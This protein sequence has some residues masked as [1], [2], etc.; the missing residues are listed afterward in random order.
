VNETTNGG[1][2]RRG[3]LTLA[4]TGLGL[5]FMGSPLQQLLFTREALGATPQDAS[6][7]AFLSIYFRGGPSQTDTW[8]PKPGSPSSYPGFQTVDLGVRDVYGAP[9]R[10]GGQFSASEPV[11]PELANLVMNDRD[12]K[13]GLVR[14]FWHG[15]NAHVMAQTYMNCWWRSQPLVAQYPSMASAMAYYL[16]GRGPGIPA[17]VIT[18][19]HGERVNDAGQS[20]C[21]TG[22]EVAPGG[23]AS[24]QL[25]EALRRPVGVD[26]A[27][28]DRRK[29]FLDRLNQRYVAAHPDAMARA[30]EKAT[31]DA[32]AVTSAGAAAAAF[33]LRGK[34]LLPPG[35]NDPVAERLTMALELIKAG[36]P[37]VSMGVGGNDTH[38]DNRRTISRIWGVNV[39][40]GVTALARALKATG[41]RVLIALYGD[42]GRTPASVNGGARD[43]RD[44]W[45]GAFTVALLSINQP[46]FV[47]TA[48][49]DTGRDG[50]LQYNSGAKDP[51][52]PADMGAFL[53][54]AMGIQVG[55]PEFD[56]PLLSRP[57]APVD[58]MNRSDLLLR[59]FGLL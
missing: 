45:G 41:K 28:Y 56:L 8:D 42:F 16:Q 52:S 40:Q 39:N 25:V 34:P 59:T 47:M 11:L 3:F 30:M 46:K 10:L 12:V 55:R 24:S 53:Y 58:R 21:P 38:R 1:V 36:I 49:G 5:G 20:R 15:Q 51:I 35:G 17:V 19:N 2:S 50:L 7:D 44:H 37:Y 33:D 13:L 14:S 26:Q 4:A 27:R 6:Y 22:L 18:G 9:V 31:E 23:A 48:I 32:H 43:G 29:A 54:R 57:A